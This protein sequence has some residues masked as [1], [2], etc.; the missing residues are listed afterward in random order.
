MK[1]RCLVNLLL[2]KETLDLGFGSVCVSFTFVLLN[3]SW[4]KDVHMIYI[5]VRSF[6]NGPVDHRPF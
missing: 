5:I 3:P 2:W 1:M 4:H 6:D